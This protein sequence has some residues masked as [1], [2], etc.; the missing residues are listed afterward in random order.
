M[1]EKEIIKGIYV[2]TNKINN[3]KYIG[4]SSDI[5]KRW[6]YHKQ[7][8]ESTREWNKTLYKAFRKYGV[9]NFSFEIIE[10]LDINYNERCNER[11]KFWIS[12]YDSYNNGYNETEGG[13]GGVTVKDPRASYGKL[14]REEVIYLRKRYLECKYPASYIW[15]NEFKNK[16]TKRGFQAIWIGQKAQDI[17]PE[18]FTQKNREKQIRLSREHE[19]VLRRRISLKE[20]QKIK[21]RI[22]NGEKRLNIWKEGYKDLYTYKGFSDM[23]KAVSLDER[24]KLDGTLEPLQEN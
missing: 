16:I 20:K 24:I 6:E 23:I 7:K 1:K 13:D 12:Y 11:E 17:M 3:K 9:Q 18:V 19:G 5:K 21:E 14:T 4:K 8:Y 2:I 10:V 15:E 22:V